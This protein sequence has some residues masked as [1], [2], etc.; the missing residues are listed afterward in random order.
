LS[1]QWQRGGGDL[2]DGPTAFGSSIAGAT[3]AMLTIS[4]VTLADAAYGDYTVV[5]SDSAFCAVTS[6]AATLTVLGRPVLDTYVDPTGGDYT[7]AFS[8]PS[9][10]TYKV[11]HSTD[12]KLP[13]TSWT[14][15]TSGSFTG[16][17]D[18]YQDLAPADPQRFYIIMSP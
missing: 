1:C 5:A 2:F 16:G 17:T 7:L 18:T 10:Q 14:V 15:L 11:L 13:L 3:T 8:G 12:V 4:N 6:A 9:G